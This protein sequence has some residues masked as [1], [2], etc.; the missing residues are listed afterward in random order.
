MPPA[1]YQVEHATSYDYATPVAQSWQLAHLTPRALPWQRVLTHS[2]QVDPHPD[3]RHDEVDAYGNTAVHFALHGAHRRLRVRMRC[4]VEVGDR[5]AA[6]GEAGPWEAV[7]DA[8][9][10][11]APV[12]DLLAAQMV[13]PSPM[14]PLSSGARDYAAPLLTSG[15][16]WLDAVTALMHAIH[17]DFT[18]DAEATVVGSTVDEVLSHRSGV[19]QD[20]AHLMI[21]ALRAHGLPA[22]YVSG[23]LLTD[24][25]PGQPRLLGAD[26]SHPWVAASAPGVG[27]RELDPT[28]DQLADARYI[29]LA[30]GADFGD[31]APLRGVI[32]GGGQQTM[33]VEVSVLPA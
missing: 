9:R 31:V 19:C 22:R 15:R 23:Y 6:A 10:E 24:A 26:A 14:I 29:T 30:W 4:L 16:D 20:F 3:E 17:R 5:P 7:R 13:E 11:R 25:P 27:W 1:R 12:P 18:F 32:A 2:L 28:N 8:M 33:T 21:A